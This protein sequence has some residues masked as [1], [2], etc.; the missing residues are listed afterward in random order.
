QGL[1]RTLRPGA[2]SSRARSFE[3]SFVPVVESGAHP[4]E[5]PGLGWQRTVGVR[6]AVGEGALSLAL[7]DGSK[8]PGDAARRVGDA[9]QRA[10]SGRSAAAQELAPAASGSIE[11]FRPL[12][13]RNCSQIFVG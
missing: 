6:K 11:H 1:R 10:G 3:R 8:L 4:F 5:D 2:R 9:A 7:R 13:F 12:T